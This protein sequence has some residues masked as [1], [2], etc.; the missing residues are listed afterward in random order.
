MATKTAG[1]NRALA[2]KTLK[3]VDGYF[4]TLDTQL[5][6]INKDIVELNSKYWY[7]G[8]T[9][10]TWYLKKGVEN[11]EKTVRYVNTKLIPMQMQL[12]FYVNGFTA[13]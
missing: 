2:K 3:Q 9:A 8:N 4:E 13:I 5:Q 7:G 11:Y 1:L 12:N 6:K 10:N